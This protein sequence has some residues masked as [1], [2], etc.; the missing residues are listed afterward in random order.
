MLLFSVKAFGNPIN[1]KSVVKIIEIIDGDSLKVLQDN[2][3]ISFVRL[4]G[5]DCKGNDSAFKFLNNEFMGKSVVAVLD[6]TIVPY[7]N[8]WNF[9]YIYSD[10]VCLNNTLLQNGYAK[11]NLAHVNSDSYYNLTGASVAAKQASIGIWSEK[12]NLNDAFYK[13]YKININTA[14]KNILMEYLN[15]IDE[16][17][18][19]NIIICRNI[20]PFKSI[21]EVKNV[22]GITNDIYMKNEFL[23]TVKTDINKAGFEELMSLGHMSEEKAKS[24]LDYRYKTLFTDLSQLYSKAFI[25]KN[26][27]NLIADFITAE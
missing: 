13:E 14:R 18:A 26:E 20:K 16:M 8:R 27:Y 2:G 7:F 21:E 22:F 5:V 24:I 1:N 25:S 4:I 19:N 6:S 17:T 23:M 10:G 12:S 15:G 11:P 3:K 9:A